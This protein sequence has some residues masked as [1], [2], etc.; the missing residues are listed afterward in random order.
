MVISI[1][2]GQ[3]WIKKK[4]IKPNKEPRNKEIIYN[5]IIANKILLKNKIRICPNKEYNKNY[6]WHGWKFN[7]EKKS[8]LLIWRYFPLKEI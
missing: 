5:K 3:S 7:F 2:R 8:K 6:P 1:Y 4:L